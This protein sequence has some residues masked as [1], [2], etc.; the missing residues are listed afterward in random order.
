LL[1]T[2]AFKINL[3]LYSK[4]EFLEE[5]GL[6][7]SALGWKK[8]EVRVNTKL[9]YTQQKFNL[10]R[11]ES[12]GYSKLITALAA[13]GDIAAPGRGVLRNKYSA[14]GCISYSSSSSSSSA[15]SASCCC[16][17]SPP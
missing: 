17:C 5:A 15:S 4:G 14:R 8:K 12:E 2:F 11:E 1:P 7:P 13:F 9:V 16:S 10:L 6:F 3:R